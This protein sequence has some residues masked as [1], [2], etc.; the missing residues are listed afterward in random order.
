MRMVS[1]IAV[2]E[3]RKSVDNVNM[4]LMKYLFLLLGILQHYY[5]LFHLPLHLLSLLVLPL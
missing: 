1:A 4:H 5:L 2:A 3:H